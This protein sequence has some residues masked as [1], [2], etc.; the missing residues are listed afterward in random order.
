MLMR[1]A[2]SG[3]VVGVLL[4]MSCSYGR[5]DGTPSPTPAPELERLAS[6]VGVWDTTSRFRASPNSSPFESTSTYTVRWSESRQF[7]IS[8]QRGMTPEGWTSRIL[9]TSWNPVDRK[10]DVIEVSRG[11]STVE[12]TLWFEGDIQ[13]VL[14]YR[15]IGAQ[16]VRTEL[17]VEHMSPDACKFHTDCTD[18]G[19][20]WVCSEGSSKRVSK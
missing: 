13:K 14:G 4:W 7:L 19:K 9:V 11:G 1:V 20:T 18:Q 17:T 12:M 15:H 16:L 8:D 5:A 6:S 3:Q 2:F 10:I